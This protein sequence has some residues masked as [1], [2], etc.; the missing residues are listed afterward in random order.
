M[1]N[2]M[3]IAP[4]KASAEAHEI[5][6]QLWDGFL[7]NYIACRDKVMTDDDEPKYKVFDAPGPSQYKAFVFFFGLIKGEAD[8]IWEKRDDMHMHDLYD[9]ESYGGPAILEFL[10]NLNSPACYDCVGQT[11][12]MVSGTFWR[13]HLVTGAKIVSY[14]NNLSTSGANVRI[15]TQ[16]KNEEPHAAA[17]SQFRMENYK[18]LSNLDTRRPIHFILVGEDYLFFEFPHTE[19]TEFRLNM[20]LD[21]NAIPFKDVDGKRKLIDFLNKLIIEGKV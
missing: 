1:S 14:F 21:L 12:T 2:L 16:A 9:M 15:L 20:F 17:I 7:E 11:I 8:W 13:V 18:A 5:I 10:Q 19:S 4:K 6:S 3:S